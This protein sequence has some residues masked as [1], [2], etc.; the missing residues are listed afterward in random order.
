[1]PILRVNTDAAYCCVYLLTTLVVTIVLRQRKNEQMFTAHL[2]KI[3]V[4][5][6][7]TG[8]IANFRTANPTFS[9][10]SALHSWFSGNAGP[11]SLIYST[12]LRNEI[13]N[14]LIMELGKRR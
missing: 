14:L 10:F 8:L 13:C 3:E 4:L 5:G 7:K 11:V 2:S 9:A 1:M 6:D 12:R